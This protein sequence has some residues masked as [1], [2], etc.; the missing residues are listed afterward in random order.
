M[1]AALVVALW[2]DGGGLWPP[3]EGVRPPYPATLM[4]HFFNQWEKKAIFWPVCQRRP[5]TTPLQQQP[6]L[7]LLRCNRQI[8]KKKRTTPPP[9]N[10]EERRRSLAL[11]A[12]RLWHS[13]TSFSF[14]FP[15]L[16]FISFALFFFFFFISWSQWR[17]RQSWLISPSWFLFAFLVLFCWMF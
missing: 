7:S 6:T 9:A 3:A 12:S 15:C 5:A 17:N 16:L 4:L 14:L 11:T 13:P 10:P 2:W 1:H 8:K